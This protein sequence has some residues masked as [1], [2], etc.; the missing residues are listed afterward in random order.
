MEF[1]KE[2]FKDKALTFQELQKELEA[3]KQIKLANLT[4][5]FQSLKL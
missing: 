3:N 4:Q 1:L 2:I 5:N